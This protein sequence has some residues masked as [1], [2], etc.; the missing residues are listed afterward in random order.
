MLN[1]LKIKV[2]SLAAE[3]RLIRKDERKQLKWARAA[4]QNNAYGKGAE[5]AQYH[6]KVF[7]GLQ[8]HRKIDVR[9]ESRASNLAYGFLK[10][11]KF[12]EIERV[13]HNKNTNPPN[14]TKVKNLVQRYGEGKEKEILQRFETWKD[15]I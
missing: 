5:Y 14:W 13:S 15:E 3:A 7:F 2:V 1:Y 8:A 10:G 6:Y 12:S 11:R 4:A 9:Q